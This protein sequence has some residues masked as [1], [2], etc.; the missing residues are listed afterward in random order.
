M[1][2]LNFH[3][4]KLL[5]GELI[6]LRLR[7][8]VIV[9][10]PL[11]C[12]DFMKFGSVIESV[13]IYTPSRILTN[14][15]FE[16][17]LAASGQETS[18]E[19]IISR[20]GIRERH[21]AEPHETVGSMAYEAAKNTL[22]M[23]RAISPIEHILIATNT[24]HQPFPNAAGEVQARIRESHPNLIEAH[25]SGSDSY[26]GCTG[27]NMALMYADALVK[28]GQ[29]G[30]VLVVGVD[31]LS[32][33]TDYSDRSN[34]ILFGDGA[35]AYLIAQNK[36][37]NGG[38]RGHM[39]RGDGNLRKVIY[40]EEGAEKVTLVEALSAVSEN[41]FAVKSR[42]RK[43]HMDGREVFKYVVEEW[44][45]LIEG[46]KKNKKLNPDA[47]EFS[48]LAGISPHLANLRMFENIEKRYP[49]F[50][51]RCALATEQDRTYFCNTSTASQGRRVRRFLQESHERDYLLAFGYGSGVHACANL[52]QRPRIA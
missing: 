28:S 18:D 49:G 2:Y 32:D 5:N 16:K 51:E 36:F 29:F 27:V 21:V 23:D 1:E 7:L 42:G 15:D 3:N 33:V 25:A 13:G 6:I 46:F 20:T 41:R 22:D 45:N 12:E 24:H 34:C 47:I 11:F 44:K 43:L 37:G 17:I 35:S 8:N 4:K 30:K 50:L 14:S 10:I 9:F 31:K 19:W 48:D 40:C 38:F 26:S 39:A 52:Y